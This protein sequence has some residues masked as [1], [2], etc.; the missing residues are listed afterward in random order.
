V[1]LYN[2]RSAYVPALLDKRLWFPDPDLAAD[3]GSW[4][5][6]VAIGGDLSVPR[7]LLAYRS[8]IF[9]W[10]V[11]PITW[12]SPNPRAILEP[13]DLHVSRSLSR[14]LRKGVFQITKDQAFTAVME[15]CA[16]PV[17]GREET[18]IS[19]EFVAAYTELH[20]RGHAHSFECWQEGQLAGGIYGVSIG[21]L[22][23]GESMFHRV[24]NASKVALLHL[25]E[26]LQE[27]GFT[28][29][30]VQMATPITATLG[31]RNIPRGEYLKRV[32]EAVSKDCQF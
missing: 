4:N 29:F 2:A 13:D 12:W 6:L 14:V 17:P 24:S 27:R 23:A 7:L 5:G 19:R 22:F 15:G 8:G 26:H 1:K 21:G 9:P 32:R 28:L 31:A 10:T 20:R 3:S 25:S 30:D 11:N 18:W 16:A